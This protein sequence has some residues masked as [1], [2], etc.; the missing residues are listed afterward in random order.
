[1]GL[2]SLL[3]I[4]W[5]SLAR[6]I[7]SF[8]HLQSFIS[9]CL[10]LSV[11]CFEIYAPIPEKQWFHLWI[12]KIW[13]SAFHDFVWKIRL[14]CEPGYPVLHA[15]HRWS[16]FFVCVSVSKTY[17][18]CFKQVAKVFAESYSMQ[19]HQHNHFVSMHLKSHVIVSTSTITL[20]RS[21][22]RHP[23]CHA[24]TNLLHVPDWVLLSDACDVR[25]ID[26]EPRS[27]QLETVKNCGESGERV[28]RHAWFRKLLWQWFRWGEAYTSS[29][30]LVSIGKLTYQMISACSTTHG[31]NVCLARGIMRVV[32]HQPR[33]ERQLCTNN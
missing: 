10:L 15:E 5:F 21:N 13:S 29:S 31:W 2:S 17:W 16:N 4:P 3:L 33:S 22:T 20:H 14:Q 28:Q 1:M 8:F 12:L 32:I 7:N 18:E 30:G 26:W 6:K 27:K 25:Q 24:I 11:W 19:K 9:P 23:H